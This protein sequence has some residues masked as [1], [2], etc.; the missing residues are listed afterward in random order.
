M[1]AAQDYESLLGPST[2]YFVLIK[3]YSSSHNSI[4][5]DG[6]GRYIK[7]CADSYHVGCENVENF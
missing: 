1:E 2:L 7:S 6:R 4:T 3:S 5:V